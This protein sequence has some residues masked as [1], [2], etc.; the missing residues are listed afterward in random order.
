MNMPGRR[1]NLR[2]SQ[3]LHN[4]LK[5]INFKIISAG[6]ASTDGW[7]CRQGTQTRFTVVSTREL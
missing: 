2:A 5:S 3:K 7:R 1:W 4:Y 6:G